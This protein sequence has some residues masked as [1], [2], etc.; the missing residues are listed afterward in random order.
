MNSSESE[1]AG[2][3]RV[4]NTLLQEGAP[5]SRKQR[6]QSIDTLRGVALFGILLMNIIAFA[7]PFAAY[8]EPGVDGATSGIDLFVFASMDVMVEGSMRALFS[9]LFG[10]GMLIFL[11]KPGADEAV[12]KKL[13]YRRTIL[14]IGFGLV[15]AWL[16]VWVGDILYAYGVTGLLLYFFRNLEARRL[17]IYS[18][19]IVGFLALLHTG[20][21][22][23]ARALGAEAELI[24]SLPAGTTLSEEQQQTLDG[25]DALLTQM[26]ATP[27]LIEADL[28]ARKSGY[29]DNF[30]FA[31]QTNIV[32]QTIA[33]LMFNLWDALSM[34][35]LGMACWK[36]GMFDASRTMAFYTRLTLVSFGIGIPLNLIET[37]VFINSGFEIHWAATM[38]PSYDIGRLSLAFG[39]I[40]LVMMICKS[41]VFAA[42]RS[43]MAAVGQMALSNYLSQSLICNFIFM[44]FGLGLAGELAR[45]QIYY[46]V[47]GVWL[48]QLIF[49]ILWLKNYRFGPAEWLWRSL[50]YK[51]MQPMRLQMFE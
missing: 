12:V 38:R 46:V 19:V 33:Y 24:S 27:E 20:M 39:Y 22:F 6:I 37:L 16:F 11:N 17:A 34:M 23:N 30:M 32:V 51:K 1:L 26:L 9:M 44:G 15:N 3:H 35:L 10:A 5:I 8:S 28:T 40:G 49:S 4:E 43:G 31:A 29:V 45:H 50:T 41:G 48:F 36:W 14:L 7:N 18:C 47:F 13:F 42:F 2:E 25:W 21:H